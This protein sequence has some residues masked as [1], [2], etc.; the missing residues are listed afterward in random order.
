[1][2]KKEEMK[3]NY[4]NKNN[5]KIK[6]M[7]KMKVTTTRVMIVMTKMN[8]YSDYGKSTIISTEELIYLT[9]RRSVNM[10]VTHT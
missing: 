8:N 5:K 3:K 4:S 6:M 7:M 1:M 9:I 2:K 10:S